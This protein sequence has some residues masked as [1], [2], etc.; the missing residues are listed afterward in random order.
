MFEILKYGEML[1][2]MLNAVGDWLMYTPDRLPVY[3]WLTQSVDYVPNPFGNI[4][5]LVFGGGIIFMLGFRLVKFFT[6]I[7][8]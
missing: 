8:F 2:S 1:L 3:N 6:D 7:I 5:G 4:A